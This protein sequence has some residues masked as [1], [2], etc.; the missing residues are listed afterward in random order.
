MQASR[1]KGETMT[2][3]RKKKQTRDTFVLL[4]M[5]L[6]ELGKELKQLHHAELEGMPANPRNRCYLCKRMEGAETFIMRAG[7]DGIRTG[8]VRLDPIE[9]ALGDGGSLVYRLCF[10]CFCLLSS[11]PRHSRGNR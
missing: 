10:E 2:N 6:D 9:I 7:E 4:G 1:H 3:K 5:T 11:F 8:K